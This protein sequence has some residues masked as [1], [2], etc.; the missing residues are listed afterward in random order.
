VA[1]PQDYSQLP[2]NRHGVS[3]GTVLLPTEVSIT[4]GGGSSRD[5]VEQQGG[6]ADTFIF[7]FGLREARGPLGT[8]VDFIEGVFLTAEGPGFRPTWG[9]EQLL[10]E[11][12]LDGWRVVKTDEVLK[13]WT[14]RIEERMNK[15]E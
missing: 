9:L 12:D 6:D 4:T 1:R 5:F 3:A 7:V 11:I 15:G 10:R 2:E 14:R 8:M 13:S